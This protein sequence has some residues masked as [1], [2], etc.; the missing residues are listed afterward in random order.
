MILLSHP[1]GNANVRQAALALE[2]GG[3]LE[4]W[5]TGLAPF[6]DDWW[7]RHTPKRLAKQLLRRTPPAAL[8]GRVR[9]AP[10]REVARLVA[11]GLGLRSLIRH[12][13]GVFSVDAVYRDLD[14]RVG[15]H[16]AQQR[17]GRINGA[18]AYEDGALETFRVCQE[19]NWHRFYDLPIG[20][21]RVWQTLLEEEKLRQ[22][23]W[24]ATLQGSGDS[25]EKLARKDE[26]LRLAT[27]IYV[28]SSFTRQTLQAAPDFSARIEVIPYGAPELSVEPNQPRSGGPLRVLFVGALSQ[29][30]GL[31]YLLEAVGKFGGQVELT[32]VGTRPAADC[33]ALE[34]A[35][36]THRWVTSLPHEGILRE[37][38]QH[39]VFVFP[40]LFEGFG[41][42]ILEAMAQG[43]P[44]IT[45]PHTAGPDLITKGEDGFI[46]P[47]R[48]AEAIAEGLE[49]L[50]RDRRRL[51][52]MKQAAL[53]AAGRWRWSVYRDK[54]AASVVASMAGAGREE[55]LI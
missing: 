24:A 14:R 7:V 39:D 11:G 5:W 49:V 23:E 9:T 6:P 19:R 36:K 27:H 41:L 3:L 30:K 29:R 53:Q 34:R 50:V 13:H 1:T 20:Y 15:R 40:S 10:L 47:I 52:H 48:S 51:A 2:E 35:L 33:A 22:P 37:M 46:V 16:L 4:T 18:Y 32:L 25:A 26:E 43:L 17:E 8:R 12:E 55:V 42:V 28:A 21:W 38:Q 44:V 54:L 45:T 31:S